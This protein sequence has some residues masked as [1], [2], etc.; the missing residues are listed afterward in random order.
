MAAGGASFHHRF[1]YHGSGP[2]T[3]S[4]PRRR[5]AIHVRT[6]RS[7]PVYGESYY[8]AHLDDDAVC[9]VIYSE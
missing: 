5:F 1:T 4:E 3:S 9:P 8:T 2:N 7:E 6:E